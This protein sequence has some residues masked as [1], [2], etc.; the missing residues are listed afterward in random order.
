MIEYLIAIFTYVGLSV[1][2][3][4][5]LNLQWGLAGMVNFGIAGFYTLGAYAS[6]ILTV[7]FGLPFAVGFAA[8]GLVGLLSG[9]LVA[10]LSLRISGHYLAIL[11]LGFA[12]IV[13]LVALNEDWLTNGPR[14]YPIDV[15]PLAG[16]FDRLGYGILYLGLVL[17]LVFVTY[18]VVER[19]RRAPLGRTLRAIRDDDLVVSVLGKNA[20]TF[21]L[22]TFAIGAMFMAL[23][24]SLY[25]HYTQNISPDHFKPMI[26]IMIWMAVILGG[27]GNNTSVLIGSFCVMSIVEGSRFVGNLFP[28]VSAETISA[29]RII[30]IGVATI[31]IIRL[32]PRGLFPERPMMS[33]RYMRF[34]TVSDARSPKE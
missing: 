12:E 20:F 23:A 17:G 6:A 18:I 10:L 3:A 8:A 13:R 33:A 21:R 32:R 24:G 5:A 22:K 27:A 16:V 9:L 34:G 15:R 26:S 19:I 28:G 31:V 25:A 11:T 1:V 14:G 7:R 4:L 30:F 29:C 2:L